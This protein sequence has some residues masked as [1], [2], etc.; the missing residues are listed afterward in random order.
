MT[1]TEIIEV[2]GGVTS[3]ARMLEIK[4]PSVH[5][6]LESGIPEM[7]LQQLAAQIEAKSN[8]RFTR[9]QQWPDKYGFYWPELICTSTYQPPDRFVS[10]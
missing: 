4:P 1:S 5:A 8:G 2:L 3:V 10:F 6:W 9:Q 7:R